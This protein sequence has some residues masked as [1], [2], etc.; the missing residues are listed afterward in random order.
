MYLY[1]HR[2]P[3]LA[4]TLLLILVV[5]VPSEIL[6]A[7]MLE[8]L[9]QAQS[10]FSMPKAQLNQA[11]DSLEVRIE[12][13][14][15]ALT[16][17]EVVVE[18]SPASESFI[19]P[20]RM[21]AVQLDQIPASSRIAALAATAGVDMVSA[22]AGMLRPVM[23][24]LSG[25]RIAT[26]FNGARI[27]SQAWGEYHGIYIPEEGVERV[28]IIRGPGTL[29]HGSDAYG[30]VL[31]FVPN[32]VLQGR[33]RKSQVSLSG[34]SATNG[35]QATAA[36]EKRSQSTFH[37]F[38]GGYKRH[39][40]YRLPSGEALFNSAYSQF[41]AQGTF[42]Y[43][44]SWGSIEGAY[45][46]SYNNADIIGHDGWSQSG[47]H[48]VTTSM[49]LRWG[50]WQLIPRISYQLNHRKEFDQHVHV[51]GS[52][53]DELLDSIALD[54]SLRTLRYDIKGKRTTAG[55]WNWILGSQG[56]TSSNTNEPEGLEGHGAPLI[57][58][59]EIKELSGFAISSWKGDKIGVEASVRSDLRQTQ[60]DEGNV[61]P[62]ENQ[63]NDW[64]GS[65]ALG[66]HWDMTE[67]LISRWHVARSQRVPGLSELFSNGLHHCAYRIEMGDQTLENETS[68]NI[69]WNTRWHGRSLSMESSVYRNAIEDYVYI[70]P[71]K[72]SF[73]GVPEFAYTSTEA[74]FF[75]AEFTG[76][77][78]PMRWSHMGS[79]VAVSMVEARDD[80]GSE[81]PLI[82]PFTVRVES[83][84]SGGEWARFDEIFAHV[85]VN[86][87]RD[88]TLLHWSCGARVSENV[89]CIL[90]VQ[91]LLNAEYYPTLSM[92]RNLYIPESGRN[93]RLRLEWKF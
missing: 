51:G 40:D 15:H 36:T 83:G 29:A 46:S 6:R 66:V 39:G 91:N 48:L 19:P 64:L 8:G 47:D 4:E 26:L 1:N 75:G 78:S 69:E 72:E 28:E 3:R 32:Q 62:G 89:Q 63:R 49:Q 10:V 5:L 25:L 42:G 57:R 34:F 23:R 22:G 20:V 82:P 18:S 9:D 30:G 68:Y 88:A 11:T 53:G 60:W 90:S 71:M 92:L 61:L 21:D 81:L 84:W 74:L 73:E 41:F 13:A 77:W 44:K 55:G 85:V 56:F 70:A 45:S 76:E 80:M 52:A 38:R 67:G 16:A 31:N 86:Y 59:A 17:A 50:A 14:V 65:A 79:K 43:I 87:S 24:G 33:G 12:T 2:S 54:M 93:I 35:W 58:D 27:E 37:S 7:Q